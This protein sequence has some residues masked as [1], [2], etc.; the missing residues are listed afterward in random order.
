MRIPG[1]PA[2]V[3]AVQWAP[4]P[5]FQGGLKLEVDDKAD[6]GYSCASFSGDGRGSSD[7]VVH[8]AADMTKIEIVN[9]V[10]HPSITEVYNFTLLPLVLERSGVAT[11]R[12][13]SIVAIALQIASG[14]DHNT[15]QKWTPQALTNS[16]GCGGLYEANGLW[17]PIF[18]SDFLVQDATANALSIHSLGCDVPNVPSRLQAHCNNHQ[19]GLP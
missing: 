5:E 11:W 3:S 9:S 13:W 6:I 1:T 17:V 12:V 2:E 14:W 10:E 15:F 18:E 19:S 8:D 7:A 4:E 16:N